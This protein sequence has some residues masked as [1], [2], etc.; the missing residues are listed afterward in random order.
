MLVSD[1]LNRKGRSVV[2]V[3]FRHVLRDVAHLFRR[4][5]I[6]AVPVVD[7]AGDLVG[8]VSERDL[9]AAVAALGG[10]ALEA[11]AAVAMTRPVVTCAPDDNLRGVVRVMTERH[12]R[13]LPVM[14][15]AALAGI[16]SIGDVLKTR[17]DQSEL[18]MGVL[19]D[20]ARARLA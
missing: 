6:G 7:G 20:L 18:E 5:N 8:L 9:V 11:P 19:R 17:L 12:L 2:T 16:I 14:D 10:G 4:H 3:D 15:E 1:I 13:H